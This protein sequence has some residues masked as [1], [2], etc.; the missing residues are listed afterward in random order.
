MLFH[1]K[2]HPACFY[3]TPAIY[4]FFCPGRFHIVPVVNAVT[5]SQDI[6]IIITLKP[7][8]LKG[9]KNLIIY[10]EK[11][12]I[13]ELALFRKSSV[14]LGHHDRWT[15]RPDHLSSTQR[16]RHPVN[17]FT[18]VHNKQASRLFLHTLLFVLSV[19]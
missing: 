2:K 1:G 14:R 5:Y 8:H 11:K 19:N 4:V 15:A 18:Q 3:T 9:I 13:A 12:L 10:N 17:C 16:W 7:V 6:I